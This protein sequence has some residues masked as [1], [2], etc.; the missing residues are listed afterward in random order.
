MRSITV[1]TLTITYLYIVLIEEVVLKYWLEQK[2]KIVTDFL[3]CQTQ[4]QRE[5]MLVKVQIHN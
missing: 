3:N 4:R 5:L 1:F 2:Q